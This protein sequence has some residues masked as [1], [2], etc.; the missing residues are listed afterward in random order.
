MV[1]VAKVRLMTLFTFAAQV[2]LALGLDVMMAIF[3]HTK[4]I[5]AFI[6]EPSVFF[7]ETVVTRAPLVN[8]S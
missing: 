2:L 3:R 5:Q 1:H 4:P 8:Q 6:E 7:P